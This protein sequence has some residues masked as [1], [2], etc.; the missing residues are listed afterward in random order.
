MRRLHVWH[1]VDDCTRVMKVI[2]GAIYRYTDLHIAS[3]GVAAESAMVFVPMTHD[4]WLSMKFG[5]A[6]DAD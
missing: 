5:D 1:Q 3:H 4:E 2:G 6:N